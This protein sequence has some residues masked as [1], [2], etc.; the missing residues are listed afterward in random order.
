MAFF[1]GWKKTPAVIIPEKKI[2]G[3]LTCRPN[4]SVFFIIPTFFNY[5]NYTTNDIKTTFFSIKSYQ[6][7]NRKMNKTI[8]AIKLNCYIYQ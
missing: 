5:I 2:M 8:R 3:R 1:W 6:P 4:F 7:S